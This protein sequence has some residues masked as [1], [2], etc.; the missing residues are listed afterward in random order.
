MH[1]FNNNYLWSFVFFSILNKLGVK[2]AVVSP[3]SRNT[4]INCALED[5]ET[6]N[7]TVI[8]DERQAGYFALGLAKATQLPVVISTTSGTAVANLYPA[9][10]EA[11][12]SNVP[13]II[14]TADRSYE[15]LFTDANQTIN[16]NNI[17]ANHI[18]WFFQLPIPDIS[19]IG[20]NTLKQ[21]AENAIIKA[22]Y[23][24]K[25]PVHLNFPFRKPLEPHSI[26]TSFDTKKLTKIINSTNC[27][28]I[29]N[30]TTSLNIDFVTEFLLKK[31]NGVFI[32]NPGLYSSE[33]FTEFNTLSNNLKFPILADTASSIRFY[34]FSNVID[35]Y[36]VI[37]RNHNFLSNHP[38]DIAIIFG[39][40]NT[41]IKLNE[42]LNNYVKNLIIVDEHINYTTNSNKNKHF[43]KSDPSEFCK[44]L[45]LYLT[46]FNI[47]RDCCFLDD[48]I[49]ENSRIENLKINYLAKYQDFEASYINTIFNILPEKSNIFI[50]NSLPIRL[51]NIFT[52]SNN[53]QH[54][55]YTNRGAS[56]IDGL[57][58]TALGIFK[59]LKNNFLLIG[60]LSF[61]YDLTALKIAVD[62][63]I[64]FNIIV[65]D[66][67]GGGIFN[68]LPIAKEQKYFTKYFKTPIYINYS[69]IAEMFNLKISFI[70][71]LEKLS[72]ELEN[73]HQI[74]IIK[75]S[76]E[77][78]TQYLNNYW[79][80]TTK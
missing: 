59:N 77:I 55:I 10:I 15:D 72:K 9:I 57:I 32:L 22:F 12:K 5:I 58:A 31:V 49:Q 74:F 73:S 35:N 42:F 38:A 20:L 50:G 36:E 68:L 1:N 23:H 51:A 40:N 44:A 29:Y 48:F 17:F 76:P 4:P 14:C 3:G 65:F 26:N 7:K 16:Q 19:D 13:L 69:L 37:L 66:N 80:L 8:L 28:F 25:G 61:F 62:Y 78:T 18:N 24:K 54:K 6:I 33:F 21:I 47:P 63:N 39:K 46:N 64:K 41:S 52:S 30:F 53:K 34:N 2:D 11:Y 67:G 70:E 71:N 56:G 79:E 43:V 60:D 45:N 27:N 75:S